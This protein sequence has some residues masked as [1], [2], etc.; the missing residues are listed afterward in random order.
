MMTQNHGELWVCELMEA[1]E[2][3]SQPKVSRN[4]AVLKKSKIITDRKHGQWVFYRINPKLPLWA[5]TVIAQTTEN[6]IPLINKELQRLN[7]MK[8]R[9]DKALFC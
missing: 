1:K 3:D 6:N 9:P 2:E 8:N 7:I 4:L 5:K